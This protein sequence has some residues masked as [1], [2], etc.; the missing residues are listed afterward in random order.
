MYLRPNIRLNY[1]E[2][3]YFTWFDTVN[4][5]NWFQ[6]IK[7]SVQNDS[8]ILI[9]YLDD[10]N[11]WIPQFVVK[12]CDNKGRGLFAA[13]SIAAHHSITVYI[14]D[15]Y[16]N[17]QQYIGDAYTLT[18]FNETITIKADKK[19]IFG[20]AHL[21]NEGE[22]P[23]IRNCEIGPNFI[24]ESTVNIEKGDEILTFYGTGYK[25]RNGY[26]VVESL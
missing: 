25:F 6:Y 4:T 11:E 12:S 16:N 10:T 2:E 21:I 3:P 18:N 13:R 5:T 26:N 19:M 8:T 9:K 24:F 20:G 23:N 22:I 17:H 14:G 7:Y 15:K 1:Q